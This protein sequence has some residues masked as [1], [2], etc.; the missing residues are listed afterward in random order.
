M[1]IHY[2]IKKRVLD[3]VK[4]K[5]IYFINGCKFEQDIF[6]IAGF[7]NYI[8]ISRFSLSSKISYA[9]IYSF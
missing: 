3:C 8:F 9:H 7:E 1:Y 4:T 5:S 6:T 2:E